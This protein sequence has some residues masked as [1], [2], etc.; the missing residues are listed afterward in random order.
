MGMG[1]SGTLG[2]WLARLWAQRLAIL[3]CVVLGLLA[4]VAAA[5]VLPIR[6]AATAVVNVAP[7]TVNQ[8][9]S[10]QSTQGVNMESERSAVTS[11]AVIDRAARTLG[12]ADGAA[13]AQSI[14]VTVPSQ[15]LILK[16]TSTTRDADRAARWANAVAQ[17]YLADRTAS[18]DDAAARI[19]ERLQADIDARLKARATQAPAD[20]SLTDQDVA[21]LRERISTLTTVGLN[22]G[23]IITPAVPAAEPSSLGLVP[24]AVGGQALGLLLGVGLVLLRDQ[25]GSRVR[26]A[27]RLG[28]ATRWPVAVLPR[29]PGAASAAGARDGAAGGQR[30]G[31]DRAVRARAVDATVAR[32]PVR[33]P[34]RF[35]VLDLAGRDGPALVADLRAAAA[36]LGPEP[37]AVVDLDAGHAGGSAALAEPG[38]LV[39][40]ALATDT[41]MRAVAEVAEVLAAR[42]AQVTGA[43]LGPR[44]G[45]GVTADAAAG[46]DVPAAAGAPDVPRYVPATGAVDGPGPMR[47]RWGARRDR[48]HAADERAETRR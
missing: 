30:D 3:G 37:P 18:A 36:R 15:S 1:S 27:A 42:G 26:S 25:L 39:L 35:A 12:V 5:A 19:I 9:G 46:H 43:V 11:T 13:L 2:A 38:D 47:P 31:A 24:L 16:V 6:Y 44:I 7:L 17:A 33:G 40:I 32:R 4:G 20:R 48:A 23:R 29:A 34:Y 14:T 10:S 22:P 28:W 45:A 21:A 41:P 8:F